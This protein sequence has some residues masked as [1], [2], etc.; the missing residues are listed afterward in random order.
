MA[1]FRLQTVAPR[2]AAA[3]RAEV[4]AAE[5]RRV[6]DSGLGEVF[7]TVQEQ[8]VVIAG[9]P[10]G[11]YPRMPT[12]TIEVV[13]GVPVGS[14]IEP[15][16]NVVNFEL[17][18]GTVVTGT[19]TGP[20]EDLSATYQALIGWAAEQGVALGEGMW[21]VYASDPSLEPDTAKWE[22]DI[23]WPVA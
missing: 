11:F 21:E 2:A 19:H 15:Q 1:R 3:V 17:P 5:M 23:F 16:G 6:F 12:D 7:V 9:A 20:Y 8:G 14:P 18:G 22:T 13:V 4:P 10:F